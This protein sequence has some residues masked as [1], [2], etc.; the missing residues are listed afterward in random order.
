MP[1]YK[2]PDVYVEEIS[3]LPPSIAEVSTAIPAF[4]GYTADD[5]LKLIPTRITSFLEFTT[6]FGGASPIGGAAPISFLATVN[7]DIPTVGITN[8]DPMQYHKLYYALD[9]YFKNGG[10]DCY[11][12]SLGKYSQKTK[13]DFSKGIDAL[14]T[15]D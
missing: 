5:S 15:E 2:T 7:G 1:V 6:F 12:V 3:T 9:L 11:I 14:M 13:D 4:I 8:G 10:S